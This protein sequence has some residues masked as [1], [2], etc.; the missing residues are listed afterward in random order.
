MTWGKGEKKTGLC[1]KREE[2]HSETPHLDKITKDRSQI[3]VM[4]NINGAHGPTG[5]YK[6]RG[7]MAL[8]Y[9]FK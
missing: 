6:L 3:I 8:N 5:M 2:R 1:S 4:P 9:Y 7:G